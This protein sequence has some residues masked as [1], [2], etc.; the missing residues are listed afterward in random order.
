MTESVAGCWIEGDYG[1]LIWWSIL[2]R[3]GMCG[4]VSVRVNFGA[5]WE[6]ASFIGGITIDFLTPIEIFVLNPTQLQPAGW[7]PVTT[8][9]S[10]IEAH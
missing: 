5:L 1:S 10:R 7:G 3:L 9:Y 6:F 2:K 8:Q 4:G